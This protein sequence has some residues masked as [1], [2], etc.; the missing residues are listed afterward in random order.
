MDRALTYT[1]AITF[2]ATTTGFTITSNGLALGSNINFTGAGGGW[3]LADA[4]ISSGSMTLTNGT[5]SDGGFTL[6]SST[7]AS[8]NTNTRTFTKTGNWTITGTGTVLNLSSTLTWSDSGS[9]TF[10][11]ASATARTIT[12]ASNIQLNDVAVTAGSGDLT[13]ASAMSARNLNFSG[14]TGQWLAGG[15]SLRG[16]LTLGSGMTMATTSGDIEF[17]GT[18]GTQTIASNG[19]QIGRSVTINTTGSTVTLADALAQ[20]AT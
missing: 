15:A 12:T 2:N 18:S 7:V 8:N 3:T 1:G 13:T 20:R 16:N 4:L 9:M 5:F 19:V 14:Y 10:N 6:Q 11:N 17:A